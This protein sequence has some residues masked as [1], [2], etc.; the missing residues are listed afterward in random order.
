MKM[1]SRLTLDAVVGLLV[2][3]LGR[4]DAAWQGAALLLAIGAAGGFMQ[5]L[6]FSW[7]QQRVA[8]IAMRGSYRSPGP[9]PDG[10]SS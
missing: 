1:S 6:V 8:L 2:M 5:V 4:V 9:A 10:T 7:L 3:P